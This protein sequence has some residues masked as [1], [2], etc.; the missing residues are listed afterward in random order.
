MTLFAGVVSRTPAPVS[1]SVRRALA[2][3]GWARLRSGGEPLLTMD[4]LRMAAKPMYFHHGKAER[5]LGYGPSRSDDA[6]GDAVRWFERE[7]YLD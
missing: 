7:G 4:G 1:S 2:A 3:E 6:I 5:Q